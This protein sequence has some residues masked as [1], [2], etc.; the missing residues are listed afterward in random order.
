MRW[1]RS[2][3]P[4][5]GDFKVLPGAGLSLM[6]DP[7]EIHCSDGVIRQVVIT[8]ELLID[9]NDAF[10]LAQTGQMDALCLVGVIVGR[11]MHDVDGR[12]MEPMEVLHLIPD[13]PADLRRLAFDVARQ[14]RRLRWQIN[15]RAM[16]G[17]N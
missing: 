5:S 8:E 11:S 4:A 2:G 12:L 7:I 3:G 16:A 13:N 17:R 10:L 9:L 1:G 14:L 15:Q 6:A